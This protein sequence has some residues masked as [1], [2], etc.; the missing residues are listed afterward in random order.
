MHLQTSWRCSSEFHTSFVA[1]FRSARGFSQPSSKRIVGG[2]A[3]RPARIQMVYDFIERV[4]EAERTS[5]IPEGETIGVGTWTVEGVSRRVLYQQPAPSGASRIAYSLRIE[6]GAMLT[7]DVTTAP[8]SWTQPG[9]GVT[10]AV[11]I[12]SEQDARQLFS[13]YIDPKHNDANR[14]WHSHA[15]DLSAYGEQ[16]VTLIF[17]TTTGPA[18]D[19]RYDWAAWG[20]TRLLKP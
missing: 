15:I 14:R 12:E 18:G 2:S 5:P 7:F 13:T 6:R 19:P 8:D 10:F 20:E 16:V 4:T 1:E 9:D 17:E 11:Y 3:D